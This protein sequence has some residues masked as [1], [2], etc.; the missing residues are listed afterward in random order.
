MLV[1]QALTENLTII[2]KDISISRYG[3]P[4]LW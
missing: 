1:A 3:V 2:T 4:V